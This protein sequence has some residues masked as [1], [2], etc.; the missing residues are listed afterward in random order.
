MD[1]SL[2]IG[3]SSGTD[4]LW[5]IITL[6]PFFKFSSSLKEVVPIALSF[7][8]ICG[9]KFLFA[10]TTHNTYNKYYIKYDTRLGLLP[11][12]LLHRFD[13]RPVVHRRQLQSAVPATPSLSH[14]VRHT[15]HLTQPI[16]SDP[17]LLTLYC[18]SNLTYPFSLDIALPT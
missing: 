12:E 15:S 13:E 11:V 3:Q 6:A 18:P 2:P 16:S 14:S 4:M 5:M 17:A 8:L 1:S 9:L 10:A 7:W